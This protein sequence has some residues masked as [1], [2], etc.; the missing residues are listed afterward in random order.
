MTT[1]SRRKGLPGCCDAGRSTTISKLPRVDQLNSLPLRPQVA[2]GARCARRVLYL[3]E[4]E[5]QID[6][7][8]E[9]QVERAILSAEYFAT[10]RNSLEVENVAN[11]VSSTMRR[12]AGR[13][14]YTK[15]S[16]ARAGFSAAYAA[17]ATSYAAKY[18]DP[19]GEHES[20]AQSMLEAVSIAEPGGFESTRR[21]LIA[22]P[23]GS[24]RRAI[25][26]RRCAAGTGTGGRDG[27]SWTWG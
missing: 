23:W 25:E 11:E 19:V 26:C 22:K 20:A 14:D 2:F 7:D 5:S 1:I 8:A 13:G 17:Q 3:F 18:P 21:A 27:R 6:P 4:F 24:R 9:F 10:G 15:N 12:L 16:A